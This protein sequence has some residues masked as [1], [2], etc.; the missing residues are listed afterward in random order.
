MPWNNKGHIDPLMFNK[1]SDPMMFCRVEDKELGFKGFL[2]IDTLFGGHCAGGVRMTPTVSEE[3]VAQLA[4]TMTMK[5][6]FLNIYMGGA[7]AGIVFSNNT[8]SEGRNAILRTFGERLSF[9]LKKGVYYPGA[10]IGTST[11]DIELIE[12]GA[13]I[14]K[15]SAPKGSDGDS[16]Y[17]TALAAIAAAKEAVKHYGLDLSKAKVAIEGFGKVGSS[18]ALEISRE[19]TVI[20]ISTIKGAIYN[21]KGFDIRHLIDDMKTYGDEVVLAYKHAEKTTAEEML[22]SDIDLLFLCGKPRIMSLKNA[23]KIKAKIVIGAGNL[24]FDKG[25]EEVLYQQGIYTFPDFITSCGGVLGLTLEDMGLSL[26]NIDKF[27]KEDFTVKIQKFI[28]LSTVKEQSPLKLAGNIV[29]DNLKRMQLQQNNKDMSRWSRIFKMV[30]DKE[31]Q[32][33]IS[34]IAIN[35]IPRRYHHFPKIQ[36]FILHCAREQFWSDRDL[37]KT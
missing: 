19:A 21:G 23:R 31:W 16:G 22:T 18:I 25:V 27:I 33:L 20:G 9:L 14:N 13:G 29:Q 37:Y 5:F 15:A 36:N 11:E 6:G 2:V 24:C 34:K 12:K 26:K 7:K 28:E 17:F 8:S 10:D 30:I 32:S 35:T 4:R 3:E 1:N